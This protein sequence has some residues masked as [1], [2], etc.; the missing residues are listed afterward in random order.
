[1]AA[2]VGAGLSQPCA[3]RSRGPQERRVGEWRPQRMGLEKPADTSLIV[4]CDVCGQVKSPD[5]EGFHAHGG[6][7]VVSEQQGSSKS[8]SLGQGC[9]QHTEV[10]V[11]PR[12]SPRLATAST[13]HCWP[14]LA[15]R[16]GDN[17]AALPLSKLQFFLYPR[18]HHH[19]DHQEVQHPILGAP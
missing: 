6:V 9:H 10:A 8:R 14:A 19:V 16:L 1:M 4:I 5:A 3:A 15:A 7:Q 17:D 2:G 12:P 13:P 18:A 11:L